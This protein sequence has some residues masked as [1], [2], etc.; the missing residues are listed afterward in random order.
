MR[1]ETLWAEN[2]EP[3]VRFSRHL[4]KSREDAEDLLCETRLRAFRAFDRY[5]ADAPFRTWV[6]SI[7]VNQL[8]DRKRNARR[9]L[10]TC[11]LDEIVEGTEHLEYG[12]LFGREDALDFGLSPLLIRVLDELGPQNGPLLEAVADGASY[13]DL[14]EV[15]RVPI[16]TIRSRLYRVRMRA[17]ALAGAA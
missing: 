6:S 7:M 2:E 16:G 8:R 13:K 17:Q 4:E 10:S 3:L 15:M 9:R 11:S 12:D 14:A 1:F 5:R